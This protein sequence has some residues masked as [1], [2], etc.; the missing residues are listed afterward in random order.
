MRSKE[1][2]DNVELC[3]ETLISSVEQRGKTYQIVT[4]DGECFETNQAPL[5]AHG[6]AGS[7]TLVADLFEA[8]EDGYPLLNETMSRPLAPVS[9][10]AVPPS[11]TTI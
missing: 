2:M 10:F 11:V 8:R 4:A 1:F 3:A 6:F 9:F 7:H 5:L